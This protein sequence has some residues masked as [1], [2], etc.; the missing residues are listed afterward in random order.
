[1]KKFI[2]IILL[3]T[4]LSACMVI[5]AFAAENSDT[6]TAELAEKLAAMNDNDTIETWVEAYYDYFDEAAITARTEEICGFK[7]SDIK[8]K[9]QADLYSS[10]RIHLG[11]EARHN[12][13]LDIFE[14]TGINYTDVVGGWDPENILNGWQCRMVLTKAQIIKAA[15]VADVHLIDA[16]HGQDTQPDFYE[17]YSVP[18]EASEEAKSIEDIFFEKMVERNQY[19]LYHEW[20][21]KEL[22]THKDKNNQTDW[23]MIYAID[24]NA[25]APWNAFAIIGNRVQVVSSTFDPFEFGM[26]LYDVAEN[27]YHSL[28]Q[29]TDY[30]K[31]PELVE[32]IDIYGKGRLLGDLDRDDEITVFDVTRIQR[33][34]AEIN[35]YPASDLIDPAQE[36]DPYFKPLTYYSDFNRDGNRDIF[37]ATA[38]QRYLVN[39]K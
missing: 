2:S 17:P 28:S 20:E 22:Y 6:I 25:G 31:Y 36:I 19:A 15:T 13:A 29:M 27:E 39:I 30:S 32:A 21:Y 18:T 16:Y 5:G 34:E 37:D 7:Q 23:V 33:C 38:I 12:M 9:E 3:M 35:D 8:T 1:M 24:C 10:T 26:G 11:F 14:K 4:I